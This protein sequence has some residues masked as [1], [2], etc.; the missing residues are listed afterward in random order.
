MGVISDLFLKYMCLELVIINCIIDCCL[1]STKV[2]V[3]VELATD[4][5]LSMWEKYTTPGCT[6]C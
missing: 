1:F 5:I 3:E 6:R 2:K 4:G